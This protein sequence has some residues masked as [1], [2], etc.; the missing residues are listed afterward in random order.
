ME[1]DTAVNLSIRRE[2]LKVHHL[3]ILKKVRTDNGS[4]ADLEC[5]ASPSRVI[6]LLK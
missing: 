2:G 4:P 6:V 3:I 1:N 5:D